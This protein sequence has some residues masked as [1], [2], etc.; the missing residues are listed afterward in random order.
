MI[1]S[2]KASPGDVMQTR[3]LHTDHWKVYLALVRVFLAEANINQPAF[4]VSFAAGIAKAATIYAHL[5]VFVDIFFRLSSL[6]GMQISSSLSR[7]AGFGA[8]VAF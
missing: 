3:R 4:D 6:Y 7:D 2:D 5:P 8:R 1:S